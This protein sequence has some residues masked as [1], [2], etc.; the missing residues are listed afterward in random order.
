MPLLLVLLST[1]LAFTAPPALTRDCQGETAC[2]VPLGTYH[3]VLPENG[4]TPPPVA[5][6]FH[7]YS[8]SGLGVIRNEGLIEQF[9]RRGYAVLAPNGLDPDGATGKDAKTNWTVPGGRD[10]GRDDLA[11]TLQFVE[12]AVTRFGLDRERVLITGFSK[13]G[14]FVWHI[15]CT[16]GDRFRAYAPVAGA[17]WEP[18]PKVC[19][20]GP[21]DMM[22]IHGFTDQTVPI[23]GR[24]VGGGAFTQGDT[25]ASLDILRR[26]NR[27]ESDRPNAFAMGDVLDCRIWNECAPGREIRFCLHDGGHGLPKGWVPA[28]LDWFEGLDGD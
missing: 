4:K 12:D 9:T 27:C 13:G 28:V 18:L 23:E 25:F 3:V 10:T 8:G 22:H 19:G 14:S 11:F 7:G 26:A 6:Y 24:R 21:V 16:Q 15:A 17:F 2:A 5:I 20:A 1:L